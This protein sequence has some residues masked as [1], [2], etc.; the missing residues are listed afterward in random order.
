[1]NSDLIPFELEDMRSLGGEASLLASFVKRG[2]LANAY[3]EMH[4]QEAWCKSSLSSFV[5]H[6]WED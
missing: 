4:Y 1:M 5:S 3:W 6:R 2:P